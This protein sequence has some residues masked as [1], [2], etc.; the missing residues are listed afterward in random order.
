MQSSVSGKEEPPL[1]SLDVG[2]SPRELES[3][4]SETF[5]NTGMSLQDSSD[6]PRFEGI[7]EGTEEGIEEGIEEGT[8]EAIEEGIEEGTEEGTEEAIEE[9]IEEGVERLK[10]A[11]KE[12]KTIKNFN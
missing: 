3:R 11:L 4:W 10:D 7:E 9:A 12:L 6:A 5:P 2:V 1:V 8:E